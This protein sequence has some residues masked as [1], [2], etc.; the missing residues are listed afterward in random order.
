MSPSGE[1]ATL[2][3]P[4]AE[5]LS[6][7]VDNFYLAHCP[8]G[9]TG[10]RRYPRVGY[11]QIFPFVDQVYY[12]TPNGI[13]TAIICRQGFDPLS[14]VYQFHGQDSLR[15]DVTG[16]ID[17]FVNGQHLRIPEAMAYQVDGQGNVLVLPWMGKWE[18]VNSTGLTTILFENYDPTLPVVLQ[19]GPPP[20]GGGGPQNLNEGLDWSTS[21]GDD[22]QFGT[23]DWATGATCDP[24]SGDLYLTGTHQHGE[25]LLDP[26]NFWSTFD[27]NIWISQFAYQ[28]GDPGL[29]AK[30]TWTTWVGGSA[31]DI[32]K[33]I[34]LN[35]ARTAL[36]IGGH[37]MSQDIGAIPLLDPN[38]G[39]YWE[40]T[41]KGLSDGLLIRLNPLDGVIGKRVLFGGTSKDLVTC[42][43]EDVDGAIWFSGVTDSQTGAEDNCNSPATAFPLCNPP[44][45]NYWQPINAGGTD[46]FLVRFDAGFHMTLS[47]FYGGPENDRAY[48][49]TYRNDLAITGRRI[50]MVGRSTG[51][52]PQTSIPGAFQQTGNA[53]KSGFIAT[54]NGAGAQ[55]WCTNVQGLSSLQASTMRGAKLA[56]LGYTHHYFEDV[57]ELWDGSEPGSPAV[58][59]SCQPVAGS[60]SICDPGNNAYV[61]DDP[62]NGDLYY[63]EFDILNGILDY[64]TFIGSDAKEYPSYVLDQVAPIE[65]DPFNHW[66]LLDLEPDAQQNIYILGTTSKTELGSTYPVQAA[67]PFYIRESP[68]DAG[69]DQSDVTLHCLLAD[70]SM[71]WKTSFGAWF[72]HVELPPDW[73]NYYLSLGSDLGCDLALAEGKALYWA[74]VTGN[75][76]FPTQCPYQG[77]SYCEDFN[78]SNGGIVQGFA[79]RMP[80]VG[81]GVG[82]A[83]FA[84]GTWGG[85]HCWPVPTDGIVNIT[86]QGLLF[87]RGSVQCFDASGRVIT[88]ASVL[89]GRADLRFLPSGC[90]NLRVLSSQGRSVGTARLIKIP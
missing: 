53:F 49:L 90:Y 38:D 60:V 50:T 45:N 82:E 69:W 18:E 34:H 26:G 89:Q 8:A 40:N 65:W 62:S 88:S 72:P 58:A 59:L 46:A 22:Y 24:V 10:V 57:L 19:I 55:A 6:P 21:I 9:I 27:I 51:T 36:Y 31:N 61:D 64:S 42:F 43:T 17:L 13:R 52:V 35:G 33:A 67:T 1:L 3:Q 25:L 77:V 29:D 30:N 76:R 20:L 80:L 74:G 47:T 81:V 86:L 23:M 16:F 56:V 15:V 12:S 70:R 79:T 75:D 14:V 84:S 32:S 39:T 71:W 5:L 63:A 11:K 68:L 4:Q 48:D 37:T 83:E 73:D 87:E 78:T 66:R 85:L 2:V 28:P 44:E 54:F 41:L 7:G